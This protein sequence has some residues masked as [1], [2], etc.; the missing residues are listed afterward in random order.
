MQATVTRRAAIVKSSRKAP[1]KS[2][3]RCL[4]G[5]AATCSEPVCTL[6]YSPGSLA[7]TVE[8][9]A[10]Q[11]DR[12]RENAMVERTKADPEVRYLATR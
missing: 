5:T 4:D 8:T 7:W 12:A 2:T 11:D 3:V 10:E 1:R 6:D 9:F